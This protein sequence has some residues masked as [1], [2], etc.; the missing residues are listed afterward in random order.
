MTVITILLHKGKMIHLQWNHNNT[1]TIGSLGPYQTVL[2]IEVSLVWRL[3]DKH[4]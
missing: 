2:I 1:D 4:A 3:V